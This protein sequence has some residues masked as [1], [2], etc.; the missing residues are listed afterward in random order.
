[1]KNK[2]ILLFALL[3]VLSAQSQK[4][5]FGIKGGLNL[6]NAKLTGEGAPDGNSLTGFHI[7]L[8]TDIKISKK[9][10]FQ[11]ELLYSTQGTQFNLTVDFEG[12]SYYTSNKLKFGYFNIPLMMKYYA[13]PKFYLE[14]GP[15]I[16]FLTKA[17]LEV[18]V[19]GTSSTQDFIDSM[20][21]T[22]FGLNFGLGYDVSK[23]VVL[24]ARYNQGL[25]N[26]LDAPPGD[27]STLKNNVISFSLGY[28]F[29]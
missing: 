9:F 27:N 12:D 5:Q 4:A 2:I 23:K 14:F 6:A 11:P 3:I 17:D 28:K 21:K 26:G 25:S 13:D 10:S 24:S 18:N 19:L 22:D 15:Q 16:G 29:Q 1:M 7:G 8:F 20:N